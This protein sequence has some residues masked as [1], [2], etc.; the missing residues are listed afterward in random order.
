MSKK[1]KLKTPVTGA[2][3]LGDA[4]AYAVKD[5]AKAAASD[6]GSVQSEW[7]GETKKDISVQEANEPMLTKKGKK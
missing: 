4:Y 1:A 5:A 6:K 7:L 3:G 2:R